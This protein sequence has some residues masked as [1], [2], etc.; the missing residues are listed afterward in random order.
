MKSALTCS[1]LPSYPRK[2]SLPHTWICLQ[3]WARLRHLQLWPRTPFTNLWPVPSQSLPISACATEPCCTAFTIP[4]EACWTNPRPPPLLWCH[5]G[6]GREWC[7][8]W[9]YECGCNAKD[10]RRWE[11]KRVGADTDSPTAALP[12]WHRACQPTNCRMQ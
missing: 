12:G 4:L 11:R 2:L 5:L 9:L 7:T 1:A 3:P 10:R 8:V 6:R